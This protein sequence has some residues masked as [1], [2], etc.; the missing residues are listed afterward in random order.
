[1]VYVK[2][3]SGSMCPSF[4]GR[5]EVNGTHNGQL[6]Y[7]LG[8]KEKWVWFDSITGGYV[9]SNVVGSRGDY[10]W[11]A[12]VPTTSPDGSYVA[13][14]SHCE[15]TPV[16]E[17][18]TT[19]GPH[20]LISL[21]YGTIAT[22]PSGWVLCD[23]THGTPDLRDKFIIGA[24]GA[25]NPG[26]TGGASTHSQ[27]ATQ[28]AHSHA[29]TQAAHNHG[30]TFTGTAILK[31]GVLIANVAPAGQFANTADLSGGGNTD[32]KTPVIT[33]PN[34]TPSITVTDGQNV[35]PYYALCFIMH[36]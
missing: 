7:Q 30:F 5:L 33:V 19:P 31:T 26:N 20:G 24:G 16:I 12:V 9:I 10:A 18:I 17:P 2:Q 6:L 21:W 36:L 8:L 23:G 32:S 1:M 14:G 29:A 15:G 4:R 28:A 34:A 13:T 27:T 11:D 25:K 3:I 22:I 35:P